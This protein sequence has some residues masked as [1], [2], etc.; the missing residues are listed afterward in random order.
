MS[1]R[2]EWDFE[3][4]YREFLDELYDEWGFRYERIDGSR[5]RQGDVIWYGKKNGRHGCWLVEEKGAK[6]HGSLYF[7]IVQNVELLSEAVV[8]DSGYW[9]P[10]NALGNQ[11]TTEAGCQVWYCEEQK[12]PSA[13]YIVGTKT[14]REFYFE[15]HRE[16]PLRIPPSGYGLTI[17][18]PIP[19]KRLLDERIAKL[20]WTPDGIVR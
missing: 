8:T 20:I 15:H 12:T 1:S 14:L 11:F 17:Y 9:V 3:R 18:A 10:F 6:R 16:F 5:N 19:W 4:R 2:T 7:E 13:V